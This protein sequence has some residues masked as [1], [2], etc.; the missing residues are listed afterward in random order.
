M[1]EVAS[2]DA[3]GRVNL[4]G[5]HTDYHDGYVLPT[6]IPQYTRA[7]VQ[8]RSDRHVRASS[9]AMPLGSLEYELGRES[10]GRG[11]LDYVQGI[12]ATLARRGVDVPGFD[13]RLE[14]TI[15]LGAGVSSSAALEVS[16]LRSLRALLDLELDDVMLARIAQAVETEFVGAPV[17]IMDQ[18]ASSLGREGEALFLDTRTLGVERVPLPPTIEIVVIDSGIAHTH[19]GGQYAARRRESY[20]A[21]ALVGVERLRDVNSSAL[22]Q[23]RALPPLLARRA[24]HVVTENERVLAAVDALGAGDAVRLGALFNASHASMRDDYEISTPEID[25]LV[26]IA[27]QHTDVPGARLTGGGFGG[28]VVLIARSGRGGAAADDICAA[29]Q[30]QTGL[31]GVVLVPPARRHA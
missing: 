29:Y 27:Q 6:I 4:M 21:A 22:A 3:H 26:R 1:P 2:A 11:W 16:V 7:H 8:R 5:E 19:A 31:A 12:T 14:S 15:P 20:E 23:I 13:L 10:P 24:R 28:A 18:M 30:R 25:V 9:A 17:G